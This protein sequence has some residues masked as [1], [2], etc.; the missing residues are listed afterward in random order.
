MNM[1]FLGTDYDIAERYTD[2]TKIFFMCVVYSAIYPMSFFLCAISL[3]LKYFVDRFTL[4][5]S[6]KRASAIGRSIS[7]ISRNYFITLSIIVMVV[8][9]SYFWTGFPF[10]NLCEVENSAGISNSL[11]GTF[12]LEPNEAMLREFSSESTNAILEQDTVEYRVCSQNFLGNFPQVSFPFV[13]SAANGVDNLNPDDYMS[14]GQ[15]FFTPYYGWVAL[16]LVILIMM[17]YC[18]LFF[19]EYKRVYKGGYKPVGESQKKPY[20]EVKTKDAFIPQVRSASFAFPL[21]ACK[22][23]NIDEAFFDFTDPRR[24]YLYYD[25]TKDA[26]KLIGD[27]KAGK[28]MQT[29]TVVKSWPVESESTDQPVASE[30]AVGEE[31]IIFSKE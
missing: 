8:N 6:W 26:S 14:D 19:R 11:F 2:M 12:T 23:D 5:R 3:T 17:R 10:D 1:L 28:E 16:L 21:I 18:W 22:I 27:E 15:L 20:S 29:F 13:P 24:S 4:L 30:K 31:E 7:S 25:L 9:A